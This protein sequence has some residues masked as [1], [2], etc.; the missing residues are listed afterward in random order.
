VTAFRLDEKAGTLTALETL[1]T[2]P[3]GFKGKNTCADIEVTPDGKYLYAS[4][5]GH[6]SLAGYAIDMASG[7]LTALGQ[8]PTE[9]TPREFAI[10]PSGKYA[11]AAGQDSGKLASYRID[12]G[13]GKLEALD[14][15]PVGKGPAWVLIVRL[16]GT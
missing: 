10:D 14:V 12:P 3:P 6:D 15:Y 11:Y 2:L 16:P 1:P 5:R 7:K 8:T 9:K 4:N 13:T